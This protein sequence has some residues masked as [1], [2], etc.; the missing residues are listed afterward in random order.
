[1]TLRTILYVDDEALALKYFSRLI[2]PLAPVLTAT[3][4]AEGQAL[5]AQ[6]AAQIAVLVTD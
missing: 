5:L 1:M 4:V 6:H 3:S 2:E